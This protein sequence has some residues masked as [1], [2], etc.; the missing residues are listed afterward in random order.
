VLSQIISAIARDNP[1][2]SPV[3][4][5]RLIL[6]GVFVMTTWTA[7][8]L[9]N[10]FLRLNRFGRM[11]LSSE[12]RRASF[13]I[14]SFVLLALAGV[15]WGL[16]AHPDYRWLGWLVALGF[17]IML[18]PISGTTSCQRGWPRTVMLLYTIAMAGVLIAA[19]V[20]LGIAIDY[21]YYARGRRDKGISNDCAEVGLN[22]LTGIYLA[23][24]ASSFLGNWLARVRPRL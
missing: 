1:S 13:W 16:C 7:V 11:A 20:L 19:V 17:M 9:S 24:A 3:L 18:I 15:G 10:L 14:G 4:E 8:P 12:E 21:D 23:G 5:P 2:L 6:Y 22:M